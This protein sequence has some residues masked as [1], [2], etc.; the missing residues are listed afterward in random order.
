MESINNYKK[1]GVFYLLGNLFNKGIAFLTIPIFTRIITTYDYGIVNTYASWVGIASIT[2][3]MTFHMSIRSAFTDFN[4]DIDNFISSISLLSIFSALGISVLILAICLLLGVD[5]NIVLVIM[6]LV[7]GFFMSVIENYNMYYMMKVDYIKRTL[8][9]IFPNLLI[10]ISSILVIMLIMNN[11]LYMGKIVPSFLINMCFGMILLIIIFKKSKVSINKQYWKY[12]LR[13]SLPIIVH[14]LSLNILSQSDRIMI[15]AIVGASEAGVYSLIYNISVIAIVVYASLDGIW[16]PWFVKKMD[17]R[18]NDQINEMVNSYLL[19]ISMVTVIIILISPEVLKL[20]APKEY[21]GGSVIIPPI[22][23]SSFV[24]SIYGLYVNIEHYYKKTQK[25]AY[26]TI[27]AAV[28][29][30]VLNIIFIPIFGS[31]AAAFTTLL[32][33]LLSLVLHY[34]SAKKLE[35]K[36]L[37]VKIMFK[38]LIF[39]LFSV[40]NFYVFMDNYLIRWSILILIISFTILMKRKLI[41]KLIN[42]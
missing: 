3:G 39:I 16:I 35:N 25:I 19:V 12:A 31:F 7:Q 2:L 5:V 6:C 34:K 21:W 33:Y 18:E 26:N 17:N 24:I 38:P 37:P 29:N 36:L 40:L 1:A 13:I 20:M 32:C 41:K 9:M 22:V 23:I 11:N 42:Y 4:K 14:G 30:I 10:T 8:L 27:I 28:S 15:T